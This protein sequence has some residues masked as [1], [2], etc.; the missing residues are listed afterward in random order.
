MKLRKSSTSHGSVWLPGV[1]EICFRSEVDRRRL[2]LL[3]LLLLC[4]RWLQRVNCKRFGSGSI[5][6]ECRSEAYVCPSLGLIWEWSVS[7]RPTLVHLTVLGPAYE[8][9]R[10]AEQ[11]DATTDSELAEVQADAGGQSTDAL[12]QVIVGLTERSPGIFYL[13]QGAD[14]QLSR[15]YGA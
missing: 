8:K 9:G 5:A 14:G 1:S 6:V 10:M 15:C 13:L 7:S 3:K 4:N 11:S 12:R 2:Q